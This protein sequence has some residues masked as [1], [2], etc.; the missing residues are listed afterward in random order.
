MEKDNN[1]ETLIRELNEQLRNADLADVLTY[2]SQQYN[3]KIV[4]SS[5]MGAEDQVITD[6]I[7][8]TGLPIKIITLDTGRLF[9]ETYDVIERTKQQ[10]GVSIEVLFPDKQSVEQMV[11]D[12]GINLFYKSVEN[13]KLCCHI[14]KIESLKKALQ[15]KDAWITGIRKD[16]T[17]TRFNASLI[18]WDENYGLIK[19]NPL[20][21]WTEKMV[22]DY[23]RLH[24][25]P[26]NILHDKGFPSI[27]CQPCTRAVESDDDPR[28]GRWWWEDQGHRECGLHVKNE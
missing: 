27:G 1:R 13:R 11:N 26:Y 9:P 28:S 18:E 25:V 4:F 2:F 23:I 5:S 22:W 19:V 8:K 7:S 17:L 16:Q 15:D 12:K 10:Y 14:R 20:Y 21:R 3:E 24:K 6:M